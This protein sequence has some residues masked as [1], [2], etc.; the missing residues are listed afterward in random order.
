MAA[1]CAATEGDAASAASSEVLAWLK[2]AHG[3]YRIAAELLGYQD[4]WSSGLARQ[5]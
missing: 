3:P 1:I 2:S 5:L 4:R